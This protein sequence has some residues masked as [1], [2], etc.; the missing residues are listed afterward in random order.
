MRLHLAGCRFCRRYAR[1]LRFLR[2]S[3]HAYADR[4]DSV[5]RESLSPD[6]RRKIIEALQRAP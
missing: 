6:A 1:Q 5:S 3:M 4:L 2:E